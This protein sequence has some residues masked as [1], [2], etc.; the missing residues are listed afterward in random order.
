MNR[1]ARAVPVAAVVV[2]G[3]VIAAAGPPAHAS[4][5][6]AP[7]PPD[8]PVEQLVAD[9]QTRAAVER[10]LENVD[11]ASAPA[12]PLDEDAQLLAATADLPQFAGVWLDETAEGSVVT[13]AVAG[14]KTTTTR[15]LPAQVVAAL[16]DP[17]SAT[18]GS[19]T[20]DLLRQDATR[21]RTVYV[22]Y[23][24]AQLKQWQAAL[25]PLFAE[26]LV[27][28]TDADERRNTVTVGV[29]DPAHRDQVI[30]YAV[31]AG[32]PRD[33]LNI[34]AADFT[35]T[36]RDD[37]RPVVGGQQIEY[38]IPIIGDIGT[39]LHTARCTMG[40]P[41]RIVNTSPQVPGYV[42]NSHCSIE[43]AETDY[44]YH[45][46][47]S[48]PL[49]PVF[50]TD[51]RIGYEILDPPLYTGDPYG[52]PDFACP[53][54]NECRL[55][56]VGFGAF[57]GDYTSTL[58]GYI[59]RPATTGTLEW[60]GTDKY[61]VTDVDIPSGA[62]RAVGR[63][64]GMSVGT[65]THTC[66]RTFV[67]GRPDVVLNCQYAGTYSSQPG[68]SGGPVFKVTHSPA[69]NDVTLVGL[70]WGSGTINGQQVGVISAWPL[71][72]A[73]FAPYDV[74]VCAAGFAC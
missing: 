31:R 7:S 62:V 65:I 33:A 18:T 37:H 28:L 38:A 70:N 2:G 68:D 22:D 51:D 40:V 27:T 66:F 23:T 39:I 73:E 24:F 49:F 41:A 36:L 67:N 11:P 34:V 59:A 5:D 55:S 8:L 64:S 74:R 46:Q 20:A 42:T 32:V 19:W 58:R 69:T 63:T 25:D 56:D 54:G 9:P 72:R 21:V 50:N 13:I 10:A 14:S 44:V 60:N 6:P 35:V 15:E 17:T 29:S 16:S 43:Y 3:L 30:A 71:A 48:I 12:L 52:A 57:D 47:P 4:E 1:R 45:W 53:S 61:R 26:G